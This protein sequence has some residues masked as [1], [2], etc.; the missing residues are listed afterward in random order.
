MPPYKVNGGRR[1]STRWVFTLNNWTEAEEAELKA[2]FERLDIRYLVYGYETG[3]E[4]TPHLQG[5]CVW[6]RLMSL[7]ALKKALGDRYHWEMANG[8]TTQCR[9]YCIKD[10]VFQEFGE[11]PLTEAERGSQGGKERWKNTLHLA[12]QGKI[13]DIDPDMQIRFWTSLSSIHRFHLPPPSNLSAVTGIWLYGPPGCGKSRLVRE[14]WP[15]AYQKSQNKWFDGYGQDQTRPI[16]LE[17]FDLGGSV[18]G[19]HLKIW[20]DQ[21]SFQAEIKGGTLAIRPSVFIVTSNYLPSEIWSETSML[22]AV[23]RR[24]KIYHVPHFNER[25]DDYNLLNE[26]DKL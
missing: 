10:G 17:D 21:Y 16:H 12:M 4:G 22:A 19:H 7:T 11:P 2:K 23:T 25:S 1:Q 8:T 3:E 14:Y 13:T 18:L 15:T 26:L 9:N 6:R 5:F 20:A 24:F